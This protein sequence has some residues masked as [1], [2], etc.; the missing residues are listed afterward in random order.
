MNDDTCRLFERVAK[1]MGWTNKEGLDTAEKK[2]CIT[3]TLIY[4]A[5]NNTCFLFIIIT[6]KLTSKHKLCVFGLLEE[7]RVG[8]HLFV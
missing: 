3:Q 6:R 7:R 4:L 2:V 1:K 8:K 5:E